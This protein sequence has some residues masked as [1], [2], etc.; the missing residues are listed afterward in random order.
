VER[1]LGFVTKDQRER[2]KVDIG[3]IAVDAIF[4]PVRRVAYEVENMRVGDNT[5]YNRLKISIETDGSITPREA[6]NK[7][8]GI[9]I[10]QLAAMVGHE[11]RATAT[12]DGA[13]EAKAEPAKAHATEKAD[14]EFTDILKTRIDTLELSTR[15]LTA[16]Q[17][18]NIR[19]VGGVARKKKEDLLEI[20]G[21]GEKGI[22]EIRDMLSNFG[23]TLKE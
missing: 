17:N 7:S 1:G 14:G 2:G 21:I 11:A 4:T 5:N 6:L 3:T 9:M 18:A 16:L 19:T 12:N 22:K 15:T 20:D 8:I 10:D 13:E 23:I